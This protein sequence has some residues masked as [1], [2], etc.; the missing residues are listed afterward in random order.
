MLGG[1]GLTY[2]ILTSAR[3]KGLALPARS[4]TAPA[5]IPAFAAGGLGAREAACQSGPQRPPN[6]FV[7]H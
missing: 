2:S 5:L 4:S 7:C 1:D 6:P 3:S